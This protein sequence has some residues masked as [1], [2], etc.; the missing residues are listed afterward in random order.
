MNE[1]EIMNLLNSIDDDLIDQKIDEFM[2][3]KGECVNMENINDK[4][5]NKLNTNK[6]KS[7]IKKRYI[8]AAAVAASL[9]VTTVYGS[10]ISEV[11]KGFFNKSVVYSTVVDGDAYLLQSEL[12]L[13]DNYTLKDVSVSSGKLEMTLLSKE[14]LE[15]SKVSLLNISAFAKNS[16]TKYSVGGYSLNKSNDEILLLFMNETEQNYNIKPFKEFTFNVGGK[17]F[18]VALDKAENVAVDSTLFV[19]KSEAETKVK[20]VNETA[21]EETT[22]AIYPPIATVAA[23][24]SD[25]NGNTNVQIVTDFVND[26]LVL[27]KLGEPAFTKFEKRFENKDNG[28]IGSGTSSTVKPILAY[29][30]NSQQYTL[31]ESKDSKRIPITMFETTAAA[32]KP[33]TVKLPALTTRYEKIVADG[34]TIEIPSEGKAELNKEVD[35][36]QQ[37]AV[38]K[39]IERISSDKAVVT[40]ELNTGYNKGV[41]IIDMGEYSKEITKCETTIED[42]TASMTLTFD[43]NLEKADFHFSWPNFV[44]YGNWSIEIDK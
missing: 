42:D 33:L 37:K 11:L 1:K 43:E 12:K 41:K 38:L 32:G 4:A 16:D 40:V 17:S 14:K 10:E 18:D 20:P 9:T 3:E 25:N 30:E 39:S 22:Q 28:I 29:D 24:A 13:D 5:M 2:K 7:R 6:H 19:G 31:E 26:E 15:D 8:A 23:T 34:I 35:L 21:T 36:I 44:V 27:S